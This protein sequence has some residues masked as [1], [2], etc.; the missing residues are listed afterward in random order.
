MGTEACVS[1]LNMT[2]ASLT[3]YFLDD[4]ILFSARFNLFHICS[5]RFRETKCWDNRGFSRFSCTKKVTKHLFRVRTPPICSS[6][7]KLFSLVRSGTQWHWLTATF[8]QHSQ[9]QFLFPCWAS[10]LFLPFSHFVSDHGCNHHSVYTRWT[11][12]YQTKS[13]MPLLLFSSIAH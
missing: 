4:F 1:W 7:V 5:H 9:A 3:F 13:L 10:S 6:V 12:Q 2:A 11:P 8:W